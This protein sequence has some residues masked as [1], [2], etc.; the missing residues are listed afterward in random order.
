MGKILL[1]LLKLSGGFVQ[2]IILSFLF[3]LLWK[4]AAKVLK[5]KGI[6]IDAIQNRI[7]AEIL[8]LF[9]EE[10]LMRAYVTSVDLGTRMKNAI[11]AAIKKR[12][13]IPGDV[14]KDLDNEMTSKSK[15]IDELLRNHGESKDTEEWSLTIKHSQKNTGIWIRKKLLLKWL[16]AFHLKKILNLRRPR[17]KIKEANCCFQSDQW[18]SS[19]F[20]TQSQQTSYGWVLAWLSWCLFMNSGITLLGNRRTLRYRY[21]F[22]FHFLERLLV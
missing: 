14:E 7:E 5:K 6:D 3:N 4:H 13:N 17:R 1:K 19:R 15:A 8:S 12:K 2:G 18:S 21:Q 11:I 10:K 20:R 16:R 9:K 22:S